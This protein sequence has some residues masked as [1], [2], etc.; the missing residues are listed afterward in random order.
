MRVLFLCH[1]FPFP[2]RRGGK[3][4]PFNVIRHLSAQGHEVWVASLARSEREAAEGKGIREHCAGYFAAP[5]TAVGAALRMAARLPTPVPSSMG[6]FHS[7][8]LAR[9]V[10]EWLATRP[11]DL[12]FVHCSSVAQY[13][14]HVSGIPKVLDFG[15]M[16]SHKWLSYTPFQPWPLSWGY[17]LEGHK[18]MHAEKRLARRFDLCTCTTRA[19]LETLESFGTGARTGWFP[20]G[21]DAEY[22]RPGAEPYDPD[23][24]C[25]VGRMDY[26]PNQQ[27]V[28]AFCDDVLPA[29]RAVRPAAKLTIVGAEPSRE[30]RALAA[31]PG[32][33]VTGS[34]A[35]VRPHVRRA[36]LTVAPL[37][38]ARGTQNKILESMAMAVPV[39]AS[40]AAAGGVDG[41]PGRHLL[42]ADTPADTARR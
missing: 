4:R 10:R 20:N 22:F 19:E 34:V 37:R 28:V 16:D 25:F 1:R 32:V 27:A 30:I 42:V 17:W 15:D 9:T 13:V 24:V 11:P 23:T 39:V 14:A 12:I 33:E 21:V 18:L 3:I 2:P 40:T 7:A 31:R 26:Y 41:V 8:A 35:D 5:V 6:Y 38:I 36:A 29:I